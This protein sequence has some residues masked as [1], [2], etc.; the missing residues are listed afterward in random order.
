MSNLTSLHLAL[1]STLMTAGRQWRQ[2]SEAITTP[3]GISGACTAPLIFIG[4]LGEGVRQNVLAEQI[5]IEGAS[6]VRLLD[7]MCRAGLIRRE[8]DPADRRANMIWY[9][10]AGRALAE[11]IEA[12]LIAL[13]ASVFRNVSKED[14]EATLR[15]LA[16]IGDA[17][18]AASAPTRP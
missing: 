13:R 11:K 8:V 5:G 12:D 4:R 18:H 14:V 7:Q 15:V 3:S 17:A 10:D 9:T 2:I 6:L 1:T 16:A